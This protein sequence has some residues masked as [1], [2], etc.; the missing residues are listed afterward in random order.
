M[1]ALLAC[2]A[3]QRPLLPGE[4]PN[5]VLLASA[6]PSSDGLPL[7]AAVEAPDARMTS[8]LSSQWVPGPGANTLPGVLTLYGYTVATSWSVTTPEPFLY[9]G[10]EDAP[11]AI[12][13]DL[14]EGGLADRTAV[15]VV[16][17]AWPGP[18]VL[19]WSGPGAPAPLGE[20][21]VVSTLDVMPTLLALAG[22]TVPTDAGGVNLAAERSRVAFAIGKDGSFA[23]QS[24]R[25]RLTTTARDPLP[26][27]PPPDA[28]VADGDAAARAAL[29]GALVAWRKQQTATSAPDRLGAD[30]FDRLST[31]QG[32]W[33]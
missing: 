21:E 1:L 2:A 12:R 6:A 31:D 5:I 30:R 24:S 7:Y 4:R 13:S 19:A 15:V 22:A 3:E 20:K 9:V 16:S 33:R 11:A 29:W 26:S 18:G 25:H 27:D 14:Q 8:L 10:A 17:S 32:Y 28:V 23:A